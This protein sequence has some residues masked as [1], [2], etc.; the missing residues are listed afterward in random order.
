MLLPVN[1]LMAHQLIKIVKITLII[2]TLFLLGKVINLLKRVRAKT[3]FR[4]ITACCKPSYPSHFAQL[5]INCIFSAHHLLIFVK[6]F[7]VQNY[8]RTQTC[9]QDYGSPF[10]CVYQHVKLYIMCL[11]IPNVV[12][13]EDLVLK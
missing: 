9:K 4:K 7:V 10:P 5:F 3:E 2:Q 8:A 1:C 11:C 12:F 13:E 6:I